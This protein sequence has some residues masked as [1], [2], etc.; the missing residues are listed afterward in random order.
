[1]HQWLAA[2]VVLEPPTHCSVS[3]GQTH[4]SPSSSLS[5]PSRPAYK[6]GAAKAAP[7]SAERTGALQQS[8]KLKLARPRRATMSSRAAGT[9]QR[10]AQTRP[11][12]GTGFGDR[13][14][15]FREAQGSSKR[16]CDGH[17]VCMVLP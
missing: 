9:A 16:G 8:A 6:R 17:K 3:G 11:G 2:A 5:S 15:V 7:T 14:K 13:F 1:Q 10:S 4:S 12:L